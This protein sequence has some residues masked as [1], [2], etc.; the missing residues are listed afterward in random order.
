MKNHEIAAHGI[1]RHLRAIA[2]LFPKLTN[3]QKAAYL[4]GWKATE[5]DITVDYVA[6]LNDKASAVEATATFDALTVFEREELA[7]NITEQL[8]DMSTKDRLYDHTRDW[9]EADWRAEYDEMAGA[10]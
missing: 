5:D 10:E 2:L 3:E 4:P 7:E 8:A 9:T 6:M 1:A